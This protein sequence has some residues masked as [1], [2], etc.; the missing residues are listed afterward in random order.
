MTH[1]PTIVAVCTNSVLISNL[2]SRPTETVGE[3]LDGA[4]YPAVQEI[5]HQSPSAII[6]R[7]LVSA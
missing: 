7:T 5:C 1:T 4:D 6:L 2:P 3:V